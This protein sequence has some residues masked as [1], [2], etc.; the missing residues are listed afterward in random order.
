MSRKIKKTEEM[1]IGKVYGFGTSDNQFKVIG[2]HDVY[3]WIE[4]Q[5]GLEIETMYLE[6]SALKEI[7][8][9]K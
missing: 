6:P 3:A 1:Q 5:D 9:L 4:W 7:L 2:L 8:I